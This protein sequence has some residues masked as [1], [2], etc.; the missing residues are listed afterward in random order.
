MGIWITGDTHADWFPRFNTKN[1]KEQNDLTR[2]DCVI[3]LGDFGLWHDD[4]DERYRLD[5]L[6]DKPWT[7]LWLD[8]N[9]ENYDRIY[10]SEFETT[11]FHGGKVQVIRDNILHLMRGNV[12]ELCGKKFFIFGGASSHDISDGIID[13]ADYDCWEDCK[14]EIRRWDK[15]GKR[16]FRINHLSWWKEELPNQAEMDCGLQVLDDH[17]WQ[18]NYVLTHCFPQQIASLAGYHNPDTATTYFNGLLERGLKFNDWFCGHYHR[19]WDFGP[20]HI[21]YTKVERII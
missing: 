14:A 4:K 10:S 6:N 7:T 21:R 8:G 15:Q 18:V 11:D 13:P 5:W 17:Q 3:I 20:Y 1:F 12:Y 19:E 9:H 2:D 16:L